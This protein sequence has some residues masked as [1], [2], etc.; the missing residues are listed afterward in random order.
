[1]IPF[2]QY[3]DTADWLRQRLPDGMPQVAVVLGSGL[4]ALAQ[5]LQD[6]VSIA[7]EQIPGFAK[8]TVA[9]HAGML[10][11]GTL[12]GRRVALL[13]GR[14]HYYEG[15]SFEQV[16][17]AVRVL[18]LCGVRTLILT[19]AAGGVNAQYRSGDLMILL[20][21][22]KLVADSPCRGGVPEAFGPQFADMSQIYTPQLR[23][24]AAHVLAE[25]GLPIHQGVYFYM[26]GPQFETPAEIRAIRAL[27][28]D[29]VGMSTVPEAIA[30]AACGMK[31]LGISCITNAAAGMIPNQ[32][33]TDEEVVQTA[34]R[35][36]AA[37][38]SVV[39]CIVEQ[40]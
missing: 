1:M 20:D 5:D 37:F 16:C 7:Y 27:G 8:P 32:P 17:F 30:A 28:A 35:V 19:N 12:G 40:L 25:H 10:H 39:R 24:I 2:E 11:V 36:G 38:R 13:C 23:D 26:P 33:V 3:R 9:S 4:G 22:I 18:F 6:A 29:A 31:V 15:H 34:N 21:H 14:S